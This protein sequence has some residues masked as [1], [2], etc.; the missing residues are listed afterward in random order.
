MKSFIWLF[1]SL[2]LI[3]ERVIVSYKLKYVHEVLVS[4]CVKATYVKGVVR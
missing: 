3:Q 2:P 4:R 1:S